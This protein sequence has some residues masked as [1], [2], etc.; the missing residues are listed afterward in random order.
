MGGHVAWGVVPRRKGWAGPGLQPHVPGGRRAVQSLN[1]RQVRPRRPGLV[2]TRTVG[3]WPCQAPPRLLPNLQTT[4][5]VH[6]CVPQRGPGMG[7][8]STSLPTC[9]AQGRQLRRLGV[10]ASVHGL[11]GPAH[12]GLH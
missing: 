3:R 7:D 4:D 10:R 12:L 5:D 11:P 9:T 1:G 2:T 6:A 8:V